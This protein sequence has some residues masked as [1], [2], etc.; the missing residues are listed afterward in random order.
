MI[1]SEGYKAQ[2]PCSSDVGASI[3]E[4]EQDRE[5]WL[6]PTPRYLYNI[7]VAPVCTP[8]YVTRMRAR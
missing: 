3:S 1:Y 5:V 4:Q 7:H 6:P 8:I 2:G